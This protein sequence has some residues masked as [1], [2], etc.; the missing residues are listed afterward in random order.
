MPRRQRSSAFGNLT[1][2][3]FFVFRSF[4]FLLFFK[5][6]FSIS[7]LFSIL[8]L[9]QLLLTSQISVFSDKSKIMIKTDMITVFIDIKKIGI[10]KQTHEEN[11]NNEDSSL[12]CFLSLVFASILVLPFTS[13]PLTLLRKGETK[14]TPMFPRRSFRGRGKG[15]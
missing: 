4:F 10:R 3:I 13:P 7:F 12:L 1:P 8:L 15:D 14:W 11:N 2:N 6:A 9:F 5:C